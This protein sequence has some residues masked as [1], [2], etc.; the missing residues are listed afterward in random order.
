MLHSYVSHVA[1]EPG[2][3][4]RSQVGSSTLFDHL[5]NSWKFAAG[6]E[7][8]TT[9]LDFHVDFAFKSVLYSQVADLFFD[10]VV[11]RMMG[12]LEGRCRTVYGPPFR[13]QQ[14]RQGATR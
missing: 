13:A 10:E 2:K 11:A 5:H 1:F 9:A 4:I 7:P 6:P 12:A 8:G 3:S 14:Q